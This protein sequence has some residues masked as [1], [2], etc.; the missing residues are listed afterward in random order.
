MGIYRSKDV[1]THT[2]AEN[3]QFATPRIE[4]EWHNSWIYNHAAKIFEKKEEI[5]EVC[6]IRGT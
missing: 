4:F 3:I 1:P 2:T 5:A 6:G